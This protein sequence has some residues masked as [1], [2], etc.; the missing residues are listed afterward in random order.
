M[1]DTTDSN[2]HSLEKEEQATKNIEN[3]EK[4]FNNN[5]EELEND[6]NLDVGSFEE[7]PKFMQDNE[8]IQSGYLLNCTDE[9]KN[10]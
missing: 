8:Y 4:L 9:K 1:Q 10:F 5:E 2:N 6:L 3:T 7:A